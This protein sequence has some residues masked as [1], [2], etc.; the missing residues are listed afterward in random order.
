M[1]RAGPE[2]PLLR[3]LLRR[4]ITMFLLY[5]QVRCAIRVKPGPALLGYTR[6]WLTDDITCAT[7]SSD[8][9]SRSSNSSLRVAWPSLRAGTAPA[10]TFTLR[11]RC[12]SR[13]L[14]ASTSCS[15]PLATAVT[16]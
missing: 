6:T 9:L 1:D 15:S 4:L 11:C 14:S 7:L 8:M 5:G 10:M 13:L 16:A 2:L 12:R 3:H